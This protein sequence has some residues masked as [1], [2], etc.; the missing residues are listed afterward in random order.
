MVYVKKDVEDYRR[1][2]IQKMKAVYTHLL[3]ELFHQPMGDPQAILDKLEIMESC[4]K[5][6]VKL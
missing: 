3:N 1:D 4:V 6:W 2:N 5:I